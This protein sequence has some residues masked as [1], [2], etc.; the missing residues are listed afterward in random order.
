MK[1]KVNAKFE[2]WR[3]ILEY[4]D[5]TLSKSKIEY[6]KSNLLSEGSSAATFDEQDI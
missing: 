6:I 1:A 2:L 5:F 3:Q 4:K